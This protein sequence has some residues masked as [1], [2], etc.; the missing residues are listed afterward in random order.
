MRVFNKELG[1]RRIVQSSYGILRT[2]PFE[3]E[4]WEA[5]RGTRCVIDKADGER[6]VDGTIDWLIEKVCF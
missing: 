1:P 3:P 5:H 6:Y 2:E 4:V